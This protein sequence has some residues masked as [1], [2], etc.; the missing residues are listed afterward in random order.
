M[1]LFVFGVQR[2]T[3]GTAPVKPLGLIGPSQITAPTHVAPTA[4]MFAV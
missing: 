4:R 1:T 2:P 3:A